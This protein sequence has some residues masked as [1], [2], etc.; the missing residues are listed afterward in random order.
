MTL[1]HKIALC[2]AA[3][4]AA[5][6]LTL[7]TAP[8]VLAQAVA[9]VVQTAGL[10]EPARPRPAPRIGEG[11]AA[12]VNDEIV[13]TY[14]LRQR[15]LL[16][17]VTSGV[18]PSDEKVAEA[19][20][21]ALKNLVDEHLK[22]QDI[23]RVMEKN[24][25]VHLLPT[26]KDI[27]SEIGDIA[28]GNGMK[29]EQLVSNLKSAGI[30]P[31]T[32]RDEIGVRYAWQRYMQ[33]R[34]GSAIHIGEQQVKVTMER[35]NASAAKPQYLF[36]EI[37]FDNAEAGPGAAM[38]K[39]QRDL[40]YLKQG[41]PF[42]AV[43]Q[44]DSAKATAANGGDAGWR[45]SGDI[46]E[47]VE[48]VLAGLRPGPK[49]FSAPIPTDDG[50]YIVLLRDKRS[51]AGGVLVDLKDAAVRLPT[52]ASADEIAAAQAK[53]AA[54]KARFTT[55]DAFEDE[56]SKVEGVAAG[57]LGETEI[58]GL[59]AEFRQA[60]DGVKVG[61]LAGP[62]RAREGLHL[63]AVCSRKA[64]GGRIMDHDQVE[65]RLYGE[66]IESVA[67]RYLRDLRNSASIETR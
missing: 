27:D 32:L 38:A 5:L 58:G 24:K 45:A 25:D 31:Q 43:A 9:P 66:Q 41:A 62:V 53:L 26:S 20:R 12:V 11:V 50:V 55:C 10:A 17:L 18:Q 48:A 59:N 61:D 64:T 36:S 35:L 22:M 16:L 40:G 44:R 13:S 57:D 42:P 19:S 51:G 46:P 34:F 14:D 15:T 37:F 65:N 39:A 8:V 23:R 29:S 28:R 1:A 3:P 52:A 63:L 4:F 6:A 33:G 54:V 7:F 67:R 56:A 2:R 49:A 30:E 47:P 21:E 60:I